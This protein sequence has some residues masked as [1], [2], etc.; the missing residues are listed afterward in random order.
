[1]RKSLTENRGPAAAKR[2]IWER[3]R[4]WGTGWGM[5]LQSFAGAMSFV[6]LADFGFDADNNNAKQRGQR[7]ATVHQ[8]DL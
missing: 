7:R 3:G 2:R 6:C 1:M 8:L 5:C 4:Q